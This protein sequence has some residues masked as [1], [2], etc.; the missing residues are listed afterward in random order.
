VIK[1][2]LLHSKKIVFSRKT[3]S[4]Q[5]MYDMVHT[6]ILFFGRFLNDAFADFMMEQFG[7]TE[8]GVMLLNC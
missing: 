5:E 6:E 1:R 2:H 8:D 4:E 3:G 7:P